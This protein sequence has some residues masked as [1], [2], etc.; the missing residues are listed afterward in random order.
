[1]ELR[2]CA[3]LQAM[4]SDMNIRLLVGNLSLSVSAEEIAQLFSTAGRIKNV[5]LVMD[6]MRERPMGFAFVEMK[7][8][9]EAK[10]AVVMFNGKEIDGRP[11]SIHLQA[12][13]CSWLLGSISSLIEC[14]KTK[15]GLALF[16]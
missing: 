4:V 15:K 9:S 16:H 11:I 10:K 5:E 6:K 2:I 3:Y 1:M 8:H 14:M 7:T 13:G 12:D